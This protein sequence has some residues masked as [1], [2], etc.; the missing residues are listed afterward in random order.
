[1]TVVSAHL[2]GSLF[3]DS[4]LP[5]VKEGNTVIVLMAH[6]FADKI[7]ESAVKYGIAPYTAAAFISKIDTPEQ[8][9]VFGYI[10]ELGEM[11][12]SCAKPAILV[13]GDVLKYRLKFQYR[14]TRGENRKRR[15]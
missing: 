1:L 6:S 13:I 15:V 2:K 4:W 8:S 12:E 14:V 5:H 3:N 10:G 9:A 11:A 7:R